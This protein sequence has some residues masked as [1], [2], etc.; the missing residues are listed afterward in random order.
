M[1]R[2]ISVLPE[3]PGTIVATVTSC[4]GRS[5]LAQRSVSPKRS[6]SRSASAAEY[7]RRAGSILIWHLSAIASTRWPLV[8][9]IRS[10]NVRAGTTAYRSAWAPMQSKVSSATSGLLRQRPRLRADLAEEVG[11]ALARL[12]AAVKAAPVQAHPPGQFVAGVDRHE[13]VLDAVL[14]AADKDRLHVRC[15]RTE[16]GMRGREPVPRGQVKPALGRAR[17]ARVERGHLT[18][19][20]TVQEEGQPDGDLQFL[21]LGRRHRPARILEIAV[22]HGPVP[23]APGLGVG[24]QQVAGAASAL[25]AR[26][27]EISD[28]PVGR[29]D[30]DRAELTF[31][32][33][34]RAGPGAAPP[35]LSAGASDLSARS[36]AFRPVPSKYRLAGRRRCRGRRGARG[37]ARYEPAQ[38][39]G[40]GHDATAAGT[41]TRTPW[42]SAS[43]GSGSRCA[44]PPPSTAP[45]RDT[46]YRAPHG[47]VSTSRSSRPSPIG[48]PH[49]AHASR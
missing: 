32:D 46:S 34:L 42:L 47:Q 21:P 17:R 30:L 23:A 40:P 43:N 37:R 19:V 2:S 45:A 14:G 1:G 36:W 39:H 24:E 27:L 33:G 9:L 48:E 11:D 28:V 4:R 41:A 8:S 15:D 3:K 25:Q 5:V 7:R 38:P 16:Q 18:R 26:M 20:R 29:R 12:R 13:V 35:Q 49:A 10:L 31:L 22:G 44:W 6:F